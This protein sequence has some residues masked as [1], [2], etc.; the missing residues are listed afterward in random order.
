MLASEASIVGEGLIVHDKRRILPQT[1]FLDFGSASLLPSV[2]MDEFR[3]VFEME[4]GV[5]LYSFDIIDIMLRR[6]VVTKFCHFM[7]I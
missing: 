7:R 4:Y 6:F 2:M 3:I 5:H 1:C